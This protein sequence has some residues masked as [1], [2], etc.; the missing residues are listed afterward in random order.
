MGS[1][2]QLGQVNSRIYIINR[3]IELIT[4]AERDAT[5]GKNSFSKSNSYKEVLNHQSSTEDP[6]E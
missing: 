4:R 2:L 5:N 1:K 6:I 3:R